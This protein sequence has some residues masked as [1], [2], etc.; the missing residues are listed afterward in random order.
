MSGQQTLEKTDCW[1]ELCRSLYNVALQEK[2]QS[3]E[4]GKSRL[5]CFDQHSE[6][7]ELREFFPEYKEIDVQLLRNVLNR[8]DKSFQ[9]FFRRL[10]TGDKVGFPRFKGKDRYKSFTLCKNSWKLDGKYLTIRNLGRF[11]IKLHRPILGVIKTVTIKKSADKWY[12]IFSC[13]RVVA[14]KMNISDA[15]VGIDM[16][17]HSFCVDSDGYRSSN[18]LFLKQS[19]RLLRRRQRSLSRKKKGSENRK[20]SKKLV[21]KIYEKITN[22]RSHFLH[23]LANYYVNNYGN[24]YIEDLT[25]KKLVK[26]N[27][28]AKSI[29]D[30]S[31]GRF[32]YLLS[33]KVED[34][35]K[36]VIK[37]DPQY[38]S[39]KCSNC[40][41]MVEKSLAVR[42]HRCPHCGLVMDRD[43]NAAKNILA[44]GQTAQ[45]LTKERTLCVV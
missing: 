1:I 2:I 23:Q 17:I 42:I 28:L 8:L 30:S 9:S 37:V 4:Q 13:D 10:K 35:G 36:K 41:E 20:N 31:W 29:Q 15:S 12:V 14:G 6:I 7:P 3:Y 44:V 34:T 24:I 43:E 22:Q 38:T 33:Y 39:Q 5:S 21:A 45:A 25:I 11:K 19:E 27:R 16:G 26:N 32:F 40:G 18:P